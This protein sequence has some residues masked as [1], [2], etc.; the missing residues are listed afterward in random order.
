[1]RR[2]SWSRV[3]R[4]CLGAFVV[5]QV[6][7]VLQDCKSREVIAERLRIAN[8][9]K[10]ILD[11]ENKKPGCPPFSAGRRLEAEGRSVIELQ[12]EIRKAGCPPRHQLA[13]GESV[14]LHCH[15]LSLTVIP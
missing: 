15:R 4:S 10:T 8:C 1:V 3:R 12:D 14:I 11:P 13:Q 9:E 5:E 6:T 2:L 7:E